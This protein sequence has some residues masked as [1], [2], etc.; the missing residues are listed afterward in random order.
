MMQ[1]HELEAL[2]NWIWHLDRQ[3]SGPF[4]CIRFTILL[5]T[6]SAGRGTQDTGHGTY[7]DTTGV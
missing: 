5:M 3:R 2:L 4:L 6:T 1:V 7:W